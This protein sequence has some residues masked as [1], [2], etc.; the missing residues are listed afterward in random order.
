VKQVVFGD[1]MG[2]GLTWS[3]MQSALLAGSCAGTRKHTGIFLSFKNI[4]TET[5]NLKTNQKTTLSA[6][7][8]SPVPFPQ[9]N[10]FSLLVK[11]YI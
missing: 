2:C 3:E 4:S 5:W 1:P 10:I 7:V 9:N 11:E 8:Q 6:K